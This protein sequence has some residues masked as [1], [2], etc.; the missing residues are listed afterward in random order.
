MHRQFHPIAAIE[1]TG[2]TAV[3]LIFALEAD[4]PGISD[5]LGVPF[6]TNFLREKAYMHHPEIDAE[7]VM[8]TRSV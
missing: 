7:Y 1:R 8:T 2:E 6:T 4:Q 3:H 5:Y